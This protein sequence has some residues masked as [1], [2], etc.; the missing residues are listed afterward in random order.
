[1]YQ[2]LYV[3]RTVTLFYGPSYVDGELRYRRQHGEHWGGM[4]ALPPPCLASTTAPL[5]L[6]LSPH[7]ITSH[8]TWAQT[9]AGTALLAR[10]ALAR[11]FATSAAARWPRSCSGSAYAIFRFYASPGTATP[12]SLHN[13]SLP[14]VANRKNARGRAAGEQGLK[15]GAIYTTCRQRFHCDDASLSTFARLYRLTSAVLAKLPLNILALSP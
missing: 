1:M 4:A 11:A 9:L 12:I 13:P 7:G 14:S 10:P 6:R 3:A 5:S 2:S 8:T 15:G